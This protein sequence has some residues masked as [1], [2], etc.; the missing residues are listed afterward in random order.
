M[1]STPGR[2]PAGPT[3]WK[4]CATALCYGPVLRPG[5]ASIARRAN[6]P[7][8]KFSPEIMPDPSEKPASQDSVLLIATCTSPAGREEAESLLE[9]LGEL[10]RTL[11]LSIAGKEL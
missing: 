7:I 9:E 11:G 5:N 4:R 1:I 8:V 2:M 10:A 3:G 6:V